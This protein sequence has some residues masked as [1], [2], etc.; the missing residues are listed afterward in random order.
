MSIFVT[1]IFGA[2]I[3]GAGAMLAPAWPTA[4]P[5]IGLA[6][7]LA[8]A[9]LVGGTI[10]YAS[11]VAW[12]TLVIDYLLFAVITAI[13]LGGTLSVG[14][15]RA[16][17]RGE[18]LE[19]ADQGWPGPQDLA[20]FG[21][22]G[23]AFLLPV[24][25]LPVPFGT[26]AQGYGFM[27][28]AMGQGGTMNTLAPFLPDVQYLYAPGFHALSAYLSQQLNQSVHVVQFGAGAVLG[29]LNV[30]LA[31]D[32]GGELYSKRMGRAMA[33]VMLLGLGVFGVFLNGHY[34]ALMGLAFLQ[35][36]VIYL[37]RYFSH[38]Y[39]ADM[40][41]A[42]L[43][44]GAT[45]VSHAGTF[46]ILLLGFVPWLGTMWLAQPVPKFNRWLAAALGVPLVALLG[47]LPW[48]MD[49][50]SLLTAGFDSPYTRSVDHIAVMATHHALWTLP[51]ALLGV[52][53]GWSRRDRLVVLAVGWM[54]L[55]F[56]FSVSGGI[57]ALFPFITRYLHPGTLAWHGPILP[58]TILGGVG[59]LWLWEMVVAPRVNFT[60]RYRHTY[61]INGGLVIALLT[62]GVFN[63]PLLRLTKAFMNQPGALASHADVDAMQWIADNTIT[64]VRVLNYPEGGGSHWMPVIAER[65]SVYYPHRA[66]MQ[67]PQSIRAEQE[68]LER[69]WAN[70]ANPEHAETLREADIGLVLVP[71]VVANPDTYDSTWRWQEPAAWD[72][73]MR[74]RPIDAPYLTP[75]YGEPGEGVTIYQVADMPVMPDDEAEAGA[76]APTD[77][78]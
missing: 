73:R 23:L 10:F 48:I 26:A 31:Y 18:V 51:A 15:T 69:F 2:M 28:A 65:P 59:L 22:I 40:I 16:E 71:D 34:P 20:F 13:F 56:D 74:S 76:D 57:A 62:V 14:Q 53:V 38:G 19:D 41:G 30:W 37:A 64:D 77:T 6:A 4:Q 25:I 47:T 7:A 35:A 66:Y 67:Q 3:L 75:I 17:A 50:W 29:L 42:G 54:I 1:F 58:F 9:V 39:P 61:A 60:M 5:R 43:M 52:W 24:V 32:L 72:F 55:I 46:I 78:R 70:P 27:A 45:L 8:L 44:M 49:N 12:E 33:L 11:L 36:F 21:V 68:A 63:D